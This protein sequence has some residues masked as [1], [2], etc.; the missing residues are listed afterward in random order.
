MLDM[1]LF[2][3]SEYDV[4]QNDQKTKCMFKLTLSLAESRVTVILEKITIQNF[5]KITVISNMY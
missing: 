4:K 2:P 5:N 3:H 1:A